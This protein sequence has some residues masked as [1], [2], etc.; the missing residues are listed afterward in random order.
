MSRGF[1]RLDADADAA[2]V[3]DGPTPFDAAHASSRC[4]TRFD[5]DPRSSARFYVASRGSTLVVADLREFML[6]HAARP[7]CTWPRACALRWMRLDAAT[8]GFLRLDADADAADAA[9]AA[10]TCCC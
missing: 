8:R 10:T 1:M 5:A 4:I 6:V 2:D 3:I 9:D 7:G